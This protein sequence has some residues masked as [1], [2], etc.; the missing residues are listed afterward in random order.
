[1]AFIYYSQ[2]LEDVMLWRAL[3]DVKGGFYIDV[4][5]WEPKRDSVTKAFYDKGW[6]GI[7]I[8]PNKQNY[9]MFVADR[10]RDINLNIAVGKTNEALPFFHVST[11]GLSTLNADIAKHHEG[12]NLTVTQN[13]VSV[14]TLADICK[15]HVTDNI[16]F[17]KIDTEGT[18]GDVLL[19]M[20]FK[21]FR[22]WILVIE[23]IFPHSR[24]ES[25]ADWEKTL[26]NQQYHF[27]YFDGLNRFYL[28]DEHHELSTRFSTP[29]NVFDDY[30]RYSELEK[31]E[32]I[33]DLQKEKLGLQQS[34]ERVLNS[35]SWLI[36]MPFRKIASILRKYK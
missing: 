26:L 11:S 3:H 21:K 10:P 20:D 28:A 18:E 27:V 31:L 29:P 8:E 13:T 1:M 23:S 14:F 19:G 12:Q 22:P 7:N 4:G 9:E 2:N 30:I 15:N 36:T 6:H 17:L 24:K 34:L 33:E 16:H 32:V 25:Y 35:R 5:A